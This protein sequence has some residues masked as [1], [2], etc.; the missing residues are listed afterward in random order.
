METL[1]YGKVEK[2]SF[3]EPGKFTQSSEEHI[4]MNF[5]KPRPRELLRRG[6]AFRGELAAFVLV[7]TLWAFALNVFAS[8]F[9]ALLQRLLSAWATKHVGLAVLAGVVAF[10]ALSYLG[11]LFLVWALG[12]TMEETRQFVIVLPLMAFSDRLELVPIE[13]YRF[14]ESL[15]LQ[16]DPVVLLKS[17]RRAVKETPGR[18]MQGALYRELADSVFNETLAVL[19]RECQYLL[20]RDAQFHGVDYSELGNPRGPCSRIPV[21]GMSERAIY[22]PQGCSAEVR[23]GPRDAY[24]QNTQEI[25]IQGSYGDM[26]ILIWPQWAILGDY[27][28]KS[29]EFAKSRLRTEVKNYSDRDS[30]KPPT[31]WMIEMPMELQIRF[32]N[33][34][35]PWIFLSRRFEVYAAWIED[36]VHR[37]EERLSWEQFV[38]RILDTR[39]SA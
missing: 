35:Q 38:N 11:F 39:H 5:I 29:F 2:W 8:A 33:F 9:F 16:A 6:I 26:C 27:H 20:S 22:L 24:G 18:P 36:L 12:R 14:I 17:Y 13:G 10:M 21:Q 34:W 37:L 25:L 28:Q 32:Q 19:V 30:A 1:A 15:T 31:L 4:G 3:H 7:A 23:W